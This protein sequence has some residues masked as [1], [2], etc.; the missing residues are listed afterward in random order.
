[1]VT[2][3]WWL[4]EKQF[5]TFFIYFLFIIEFIYYVYGWCR[6][7]WNDSVL[8]LSWHV[9]LMSI[10]HLSQP[11]PHLSCLYLHLQHGQ[12]QLR[13]CFSRVCHCSHVVSAGR[14]CNCLSVVLIGLASL[15]GCTQI[16]DNNGI[17]PRCWKVMENKPNGCRILDPCT[18]FRPLHCLLSDKINYVLCVFTLLLVKN[19]GNMLVFHTQSDWFSQYRYEN[20]YSLD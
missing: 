20:L 6:D 4:Y 13:H 2:K 16:L 10:R 15:S 3:N 19:C 14:P 17:R 1:M 11:Q 5:L 9:Q 8:Q 18:C 12:L 7:R